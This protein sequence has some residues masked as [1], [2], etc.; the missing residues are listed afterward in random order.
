MWHE[1]KRIEG[2]QAAA[3]T[4]DSDAM[5]HLAHA[6]K[7][8]DPV[9]AERWLRSAAD[10]GNLEAVHKLGLLLWHR[11][12]HEGGE[13]L[14]QKAAVN[15]YQDAIATMGQFCEKRG[16]FEGADAWFCKVSADD[17]SS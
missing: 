11:G 6:V 12:E 5:L 4:G 8:S 1:R 14:V 15:G 10:L 16:D 2:W 7:H 9:E 17:D 13:D 3:E